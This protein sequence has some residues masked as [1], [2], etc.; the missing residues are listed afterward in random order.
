LSP[1]SAMGTPIR[2]LSM[3]DST[4]PIFDDLSFSLLFL[5]C[6]LFLPFKFMIGGLHVDDSAGSV[7]PFTFFFTPGS[8]N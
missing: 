3:Y 1:F 7:Y 8:F 4:R 6:G 5:P 2:F